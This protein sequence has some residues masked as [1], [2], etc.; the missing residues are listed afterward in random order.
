MFQK[1]R[2]LAFY[3]VVVVST[4]PSA[5][6]QVF[7]VGGSVS[8]PKAVYSPD[9][10]YSAEAQRTKLEG[11]CVL[12]LVVGSDGVPRNIRVARTAGMGLDEEAIKAVSTW[13]FD[14]LA[15]TASLSMSKSTCKSASRC[16][17]TPRSRHSKLAR[18]QATHTPHSMSIERILLAK[19]LVET[20]SLLHITSRKLRTKASLKRS[21]RWQKESRIGATIRYRLICGTASRSAATVETVKKS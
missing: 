7:R 10:V 19:G 21:S 11:F 13:R 1:I 6:A 17:L 20:R 5:T 16:M 9:P 3:L 4:L 18:M 2:A 8:A 15:R 14:L 12:W